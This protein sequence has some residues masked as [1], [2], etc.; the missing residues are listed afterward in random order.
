M[1]QACI[2]LLS[3][4]GQ[5]KDLMV[6]QLSMHVHTATP[7]SHKFVKLSF[8]IVNSALVDVSKSF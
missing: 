7:V 4:A 3:L 5:L 1:S 2:L 8:T 6:I